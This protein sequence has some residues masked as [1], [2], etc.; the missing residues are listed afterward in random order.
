MD[1]KSY[2]EQAT[3]ILIF[4]ISFSCY[5]DKDRHIDQMESKS[6]RPM[7]Y[8]DQFL[9]FTCRLVFKLRQTTLYNFLKQEMSKLLPT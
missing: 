5:L 1:N 3:F 8:N 9:M 2:S 6:S 7:T 4:K